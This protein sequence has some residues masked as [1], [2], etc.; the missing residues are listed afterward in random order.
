ME[1]CCNSFKEG[2]E[3]GVFYFYEA[4]Q[5]Y[6]IDGYDVKGE[7]IINYCPNCGKDLRPSLEVLFK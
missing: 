2:V 4:D 1:Y 7:Y 5:R 6:E 3:E